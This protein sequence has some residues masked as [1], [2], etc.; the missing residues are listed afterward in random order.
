MHAGLRPR[1]RKCPIFRLSCADVQVEK[2]AAIPLSRGGETHRSRSRC[3]FNCQ[4]PSCVD[5]WL[6]VYTVRTGKFDWPTCIPSD[7]PS[8]EVLHGNLCA[9]LNALCNLAERLSGLFILARRS[10]LRG[11]ALHGVTLPRSWFVNIILSWTDPRKDSSTLFAFVVNMIDLMQRID[12]QVQRY[13]TPASDVS[14]EEQFIADG[15]R[16]T[17]LTG[18]LYIARM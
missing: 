9:D 6:I 11:G 13:L 10:Q 18:S 8:S 1:Q 12:A 15:N 16:M 5:L 3:V 2:V 7:L 14:I 17:D 4:R